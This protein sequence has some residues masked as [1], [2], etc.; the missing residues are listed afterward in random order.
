MDT[1]IGVDSSTTATKAIAFDRAGT[2]LAEGRAAI[3]MS[4]PG[5]GAFEQEPGAWWTALVDA[6]SDLAGKIDLATVRA[7]TIANQRETVGFLDA[8]GESVRPALVWLDERGR[9]DIEIMADALGA[10]RLHRISGKAPDLTP[11]VYKLNWLRRAEPAAFARVAHVVDVHGYLVR[12][13]T[14]NGRT[15]WASADPHGFYDLEHKRLSPEILGWLG[16]TE[17]H[18]LQPERP[19]TVLG[20]VTEEAATAAGLPAGIPVAAGGGDG[21]CAGLGC[22]ILE[23]GAAY[24]NL[25][26][27]TVLG[28]YSQDY[29]V[30]RAFR[31]V[32]SLTGAGYLCEYVLR[33][34]AFLTDWLMAS[35][36]RQGTDPASFAR[37]EQEAA[38]VPAGSC[39]LLLLPY[40][41]GVMQPHWDPDARGALVGLSAEHRQG[42]VYRALIEGIALD[43]ASGCQAIEAAGGI[44]IDRFVAIGGG[45]RSELWRQIVADATGKEVQ[46]SDTV[47][48]SCLG[49]AM[50]A[51]TAAGWYPDVADASRAMAG[52]LRERR[53]PDPATHARYRKLRELHAGLY[54]ALQ[55]TYAGLAAF[56]EESRT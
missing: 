29:V 27:A 30:D 44:P 40:W 31:T 51:A 8:A 43:L 49:A 48:A 3:P 12:R 54:P 21:Q 13:L 5:P 19:G 52:R 35:L 37:M 25:G 41:S 55:R 10:D 24:L 34:G 9:P 53:L 47:E 2:P 45:A 56:R 11:A 4:Q 28:V 26:T 16:L 38:S 15:S 46:V 18:F 20:T 1:V 7:L 32:S 36:L 22:S 6:L 17:G 23:P 33:T 39:G 50:V 14:G 42:H